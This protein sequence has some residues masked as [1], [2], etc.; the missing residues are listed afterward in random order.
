M[1]HPLKDLKRS[2]VI[3]VM[4]LALQLF[5]SAASAQEV[6][7]D[8]LKS[9][10]F[11]TKMI[12]GLKQKCNTLQKIVN[13][14]SEK[15][16]QRMQEKELKLKY[17]LKKKD[18]ALAEDLFTSNIDSQYKSFKNGTLNPIAKNSYNSGSLYLPDLDSL[19]TSLDFLNQ[20]GNGLPQVSLDKSAALKSLSGAAASLQEQMNLANDLKDFIKLRETSLKSRLKNLGLS[21]QLMQMNKEAVYFEQR[22]AEYKSLIKDKEQF[23]NKIIDKVRTLPAFQNFWKRNSMLAQ[24]F[25]TQAVGGNATYGIEG[26]QSRAAVIQQLNQTFCGTGVN[27]SNGATMPAFQQQFQQ[28]QSQ[29]SSIKDKLGNAIFGSE[30]SNSD[31]TQPDFKPNSQKT[32]SFLKRLQYGLNFQSTPGNNFLPVTSDIAL[33][34][35]YKLSD[36][37][38]AGI[39]ISYKMGW[40]SSWKDITITNEGFGLRSYLDIKAKGNFW[41]SGGFELNYLQSFK[42][43]AELNSNYKFSL[44]LW[45]QS[46]LIGLSKKIQTIPSSVNHKKTKESKVQI[47]YDFLSNKQYPSTPAIKFRVGWGL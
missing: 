31:L 34:L 17:S 10:G 24:L 42:S 22:I 36:K 14:Q 18:S 13:K 47:L 27:N 41:L 39:G 1:T 7:K 29:I 35:G 19:K 44:G 4:F 26:L 30:S 8:K 38:A 21:K 45:Q 3:S 23:K 11:E 6:N 43:I 2:Y 28:A 33:S 16:L 32:K 15:L 40:G 12:D 37:S 9:D 5:L 46:G 20:S 25:P